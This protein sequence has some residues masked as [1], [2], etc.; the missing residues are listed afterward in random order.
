MK[1]TAIF[2]EL[3]GE[4]DLGLRCW[5]LC[6]LGPEDKV[7]MDKWCGVRVPPFKLHVWSLYLC[8]HSLNTPKL[9]CDVFAKN[10]YMARANVLVLL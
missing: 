9:I 10:I 6:L 8:P 3:C 7:V 1:T 2:L 5:G 4:N